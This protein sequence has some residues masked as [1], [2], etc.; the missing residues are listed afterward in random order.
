MSLKNWLF[1]VQCARYTKYDHTNYQFNTTINTSTLQDITKAAQQAAIDKTLQSKNDEKALINQAINDSIKKV[2][3]VSLQETAQKGESEHVVYESDY[4]YNKP[5]CKYI[6]SIVD[7]IN[8]RMSLPAT[9]EV[10]PN[11]S[12]H[13]PHCNIGI[14]SNDEEIGNFWVKC[15]V[16]YTWKEPI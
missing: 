13:K 12:I 16:Q 11:F 3:L 8:S 1:N 5:M 6:S 2:T 15:N 14:V 10:V 9:L 7:D 4:N